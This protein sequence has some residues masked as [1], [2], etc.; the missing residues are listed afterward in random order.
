MSKEL[1]NE[2]SRIREMMTF[3][4]NG[5]N[6]LNESGGLRVIAGFGKR[7]A[8]NS[9]DDMI[10]LYGDEVGDILNKIVKLADDDL[11]GLFKNI[12][13]L[14]YVN[15]EAAKVF[16]TDLR[17]VL[18][19][20]V[21]SSLT[22]LKDFL[23]ENISDIDDVD[24]VI[25]SYIDKQFGSQGD[26]LKE[27]LGDMVKDESTS[28]RST[29]KRQNQFKN[30]DVDGIIDDMGREGDRVEG[31]IDQ[32]DIPQNDRAILKRYWTTLWI[33]KESFYDTLRTRAQ[34][35]GEDAAQIKAYSD[36][37]IEDLIKT[38]ANASKTVKD[39]DALKALRAAMSKT[40]WNSLPKWVRILL[41]SGIVTEG[42]AWSVGSSILGILLGLF[43]IGEAKME[44]QKEALGIGLSG[45]INKLEKDNEG[46]ILQSLYKED[47]SLF[48]ATGALL[49]RYEINY[50]SDGSKLEIL[51]KD[52][53]FKL[54]REYTLDDINKHL[55]ED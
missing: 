15:D 1:I 36:A 37:E 4:N 8:K 48:D 33:K 2:V 41:I 43:S 10:R 55:Q 24:G 30:G 38:S 19:T 52:D 5:K 23:E 16:R 42:A 28:I 20:D 47:S 32:L 21:D 54:V 53:N 44:E 27:A 50:Y 46:K 13:D 29:A 51:D 17:A 7:L 9:I 22:R 35:A 25:S 39:Q 3:L 14:K 26:E 40:M 12:N 18:P 34:L 11:D 31:A 45:G 6:L 49:P